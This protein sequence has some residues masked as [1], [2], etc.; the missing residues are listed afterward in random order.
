[1]LWKDI[2]DDEAF[3]FVGV[4]CVHIVKLP[5]FKPPRQYKAFI[6]YWNQSTEFKEGF[7]DLAAA[8]KAL[9]KYLPVF[10]EKRTAELLM[11]KKKLCK[12]SRSLPKTE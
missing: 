3:A 4:I 9:G 12:K 10:I 5:H 2:N 11:A 6:S 1:M 7:S 8:K